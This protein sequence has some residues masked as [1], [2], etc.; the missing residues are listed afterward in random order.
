MTW[1]EAARLSDVA[2]TE[3]SFQAIYAFR[4]GNLA[5]PGPAREIVAK[6][7][8]RVAQSKVVI[9]FVL[10]ILSVGAGLALRIANA[11]AKYLPAVQI[12]LGTFQAGVLTGLLALDVA[13]LWWAG[14]QILPT[15][16]SSGSLPVLEALPIDE[17]TLRWT[18]GILYLRLFDYP[19]LT[20]LITTPLAVGLVLGPLAG[21]AI[22][23]GAFAAV[24]LS[25]SLSLVTGRFFLRRVQGSRSGGGATIVRWSYL[26]LWLIPVF[27][28][29]VFVVA[30][31]AFIEWLARIAAGGPS[32][33]SHLLLL[34]FPFALATLPALA[35][36]GPTGLGLDP[37]GWGFLGAGI[38]LYAA[39][40][41]WSLVWVM[42]SVRRVGLLPAMSEVPPMARPIRVRPQRP[43]LA[44]LTK[45]MRIASR[46]P[47]YAFLI[48]LPVLDAI[49]IGLL[50]Y[51]SPSGTSTT[52]SIALAAV[53]TAAVL[54][55]F[56]GPAF[57]AVEV[58]AYSYGRTLPIADRTLVAG[59]S[60]LVIA[61]YL[62]AAGTVLGIA[63][64]RIF[65][66]LVFSAFIFAEL[67]AVAAAAFLE[68][69]M[70]FR[71]ARARGMPITNLYAGA[72]F[73]VLVSVPG[74]VIAALPLV[75]FEIAGAGG[76]GD[77]LLAMALV[78]L[79][80]LALTAPY[81]FGRGES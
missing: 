45:D 77:G 70:L 33:L 37:A 53:T 16:L 52:F 27:S 61:M 56:F 30:A 76:L 25:L 67:P 35:A 4:Q 74:V 9:S 73:A 41:S 68:I 1:R 47:G 81:A 18:A 34:A 75:A 13:F 23:P 59:K 54:A 12:P 28:L 22:L 50:T 8:R 10:A 17:K 64:A 44:V 51:V 7:R 39:L 65:E 31:P 71:R 42:A 11:R 3:L 15:F 6:S 2:Y 14:M 79:S 29:F 46:T 20:V 60:L 58:F 55:T 66:P 49:A 80:A 26:V 24:G 62:V 63:L 69:G 48:L 78:S 43:V 5:P 36:S 40:A 21:L 38:L 57:F 32:L 19:A 72:W